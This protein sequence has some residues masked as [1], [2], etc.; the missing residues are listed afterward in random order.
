MTDIQEEVEGILK[1]VNGA[2]MQAFR[3]GKTIEQKAYIEETILNEAKQAL[4][5]LIQA[6]VTKAREV[7]VPVKG[8]EGLYEVSNTGKV[9]SLP[10][11]RNTGSLLSQS[12]RVRKYLCVQLCKDNVRKSYNTHRLV[13]EAFLSNPEHKPTVNHKDSDPTNNDVS[14]LEWATYQENELHA[15]ANGKVVWNKGRMGI[16]AHKP[17]L[18]T[19]Q[20]GKDGEND[21]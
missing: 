15:H 10:R 1:T 18:A 8:Y 4:T 12:T 5:T 20:T 16:P 11:G 6:E 14:N 19:L 13:A 9:R 21:G 3:N 2:F 17:R 7:F